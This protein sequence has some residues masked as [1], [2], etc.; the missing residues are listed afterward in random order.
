M[1]VEVT[2]IDVGVSGK[3]IQARL[4][5]SAFNM[6]SMTDDTFKSHIKEKMA[7]EL[8]SHLLENNLIEFTKTTLPHTDSIRIN[9]RCFL[10]PDDTVRKVRQMVAK[11]NRL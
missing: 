6:L 1:A 10:T 9:A 7:C 5:I 2:E 4:D 11:P 3:L 8:V